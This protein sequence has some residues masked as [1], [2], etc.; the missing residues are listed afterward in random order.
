MQYVVHYTDVNRTYS[1]LKSVHRIS[2]RDC[3]APA[4]IAMTYGHCTSCLR[5]DI[6]LHFTP[7]QPHWKNIQPHWKFIQPTNIS[8]TPSTLQQ[9]QQHI[10]ITPLKSDALNGDVTGGR[11]LEAKRVQEQETLTENKHTTQCETIP[12][13]DFVANSM[14]FT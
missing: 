12:V 9:P 3:S 13:P 11:L 10:R 5:H 7:S 4:V 2:T 8:P 14:V 6:I 1:V